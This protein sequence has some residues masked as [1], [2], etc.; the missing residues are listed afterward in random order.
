VV[1]SRNEN[2]EEESRPSQEGRL[3]QPFQ[4][5]RNVPDPRLAFHPPRLF[6]SKIQGLRSLCWILGR[7]T[8]DLR[9]ASG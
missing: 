6:V 8:E 3:E 4:R 1:N 9:T 2:P 7:S 5:L